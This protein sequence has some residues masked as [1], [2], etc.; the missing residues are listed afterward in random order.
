MKNRKGFTLVEML[1]IITMLVVISLFAFPMI[2]SLMNDSN[3]S[4]SKQFLKSLYSAAET[5][6]EMNYEKY[7]NSST[8]YISAKNLVEEGLLQSN[9]IN[10]TTKITL[11]DEDGV[12]EVSRNEDNSFHFNYVINQYITI[13]YIEDLIAILNDSNDYQNKVILLNRDLDFNDNSSYKD[14]NTSYHGTTIKSALTSGNLVSK[15]TPF[16][17]KINGNGYK[18]ANIY[19]DHSDKDNVGLFSSLTGATI[20]NITLSGKIDGKNYVGLLAGTANGGTILSNIKVN[21]QFVYNSSVASSYVGGLIGSG[22]NINIHDIEAVLDFSVNGSTIGGIIGNLDHSTMNNIVQ[23]GYINGND[24]I[25]GLIGNSTNNIVG[26]ASSKG[27][28]LG[29]TNVGGII[30]NSSSDT[31]TLSNSSASISGT[32]SAGGLIGNAVK[33]SLASSYM[34]GEVTGQT[35]LGGLIGYAQGSSIITKSYSVS[36]INGNSNIGG[37]VGQLSSSSLNNCYSTSNIG[38]SGETTGG[39]VGSVTSSTIEKS[40]YS[41]NIVNNTAGNFGGLIGIATNSTLSYSYF[42]KDLCSN[43]SIG[44]STA[45]TVTSF[46]GLSEIQ[47]R[48]SASY[49]T[50]DFTNIWKMSENDYPSL[51]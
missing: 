13:H 37:V 41:G 32:T 28:I 50:W 7:N 24:H 42:N 40:Y 45:N 14:I 27:R 25:G 23:D 51:R 48:N 5:Y 39:L 18:I 38:S 12:I 26:G 49:N 10:P 6:V 20:E 9:L 17:G 35:N 15:E 8:H 2:I 33:T 44:S 1:G 43:D 3:T 36:A 16:K 21:T 29:V 4:K 46:D 22:E 11:L 19:I 47:M 31:V 34:N 30:G